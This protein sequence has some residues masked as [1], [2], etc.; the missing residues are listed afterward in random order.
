MLRT[1]SQAQAHALETILGKLGWKLRR[2]PFS[3]SEKNQS[4][5]QR[6]EILQGQ[7]PA[8]LI[9]TADNREYEHIEATQKHT[10]GKK[11]ANRKQELAG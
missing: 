8:F 2:G 3:Y 9:D 4:T 1:I 7:N 6:C 11:Q 5:L 10:A